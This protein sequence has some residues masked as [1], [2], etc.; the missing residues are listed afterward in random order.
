MAEDLAVATEKEQQAM[1]LLEQ[2]FKLNADALK[3]R[4]KSVAAEK[5]RQADTLRELAFTFRGDAL[6]LREKYN[7][8]LSVEYAKQMK[9]TSEKRKHVG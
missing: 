5:E 2:A 6:K 1:N 3:I 4:Q 7:T 9:S 8:G